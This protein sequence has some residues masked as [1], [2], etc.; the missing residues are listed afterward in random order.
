MS[1][2]KLQSLLENYDTGEFPDGEGFQKMVTD[3]ICNPNATSASISSYSSLIFNAIPQFLKKQMEN[4]DKQVVGIK[5]R[6]LNILS[7]YIKARNSKLLSN[8]ILLKV[9]PLCRS[10]QSLNTSV[11][12][13]PKS[14]ARH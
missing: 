7:A 5:V 14:K 6:S 9:C 4:K 12:L 11:T 10:L 3:I 2:A 1:E 8:A 13:A